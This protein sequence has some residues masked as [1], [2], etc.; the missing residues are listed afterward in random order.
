MRSIFK[1]FVVI[2]SLFLLSGCLDVEVDS[3]LDNGTDIILD[4]DDLNIQSNGMIYDESQDVYEVTQNLLLDEMYQTY[5]IIW[6][7]QNDTYLSDEGVVTRPTNGHDITVELIAHVLEQ[8]KTFTI[9]ILTIE[10]VKEPEIYQYYM[11]V[12]SDHNGFS[13]DTITR[14]Y[15]SYTLSISDL[16]VEGSYVLNDG[17]DQTV[18]VSF[19]LVE[20]EESHTYKHASKDVWYY[21]NDGYIEIY[22]INDDVYELV[23]LTTDSLQFVEENR[24]Y[25][26]DRSEIL[27]NDENYLSTYFDML[28]VSILYPIS[29]FSYSVDGIL[30]HGQFNTIQTEHFIILINNEYQLLFYK[31]EEKLELTMQ[32]LFD[33]Y[34]Q[35]YIDNYQSVI[36][37]ESQD[38]LD[39]IGETYDKDL[40]SDFKS[41]I[42]DFSHYS[43]Y[44]VDHTNGQVQ[45]IF[46]Q[47][48]GYVEYDGSGFKYYQTSDSHPYATHIGYQLNED[49]TKVEK[50]Y[51]HVSTYV[52]DLN[53]ILNDDDFSYV[54]VDNTYYLTISRSLFAQRYGIVNQYEGNNVYIKVDKNNDLLSFD[55]Y[56][57]DAWYLK[58]I[59]YHLS[60]SLR[61]DLDEVKTTVSSS[62]NDD[63]LP[64]KL[65]ETYTFNELNNSTRD[66]IFRINLD[67]GTYMIDASIGFLI[68]DKDGQIL[69]IEKHN[70]PVY[71]T[72]YVTL[73]EPLDAFLYANVDIHGDHYLSVEAIDEP[74]NEELVFTLDEDIE[75]D[76]MSDFDE[77]YIEHEV[78]IAKLYK[79]V[80][81]SDVGISMS[82]FDGLTTHQFWSTREVY[83][84]YVSLDA[85]ES[86]LF[87]AYDD[88]TIHI[89]EV[90]VEPITNEQKVLDE[91]QSM[92]FM[93]Q[94]T[95]DVPLFTFEVEDGMGYLQAYSAI[96]NWVGP[97]SEEHLKFSEQ[98]YRMHVYDSSGNAVDALNLSPGIYTVD[99]EMYGVFDIFYFDLK[100]VK[101]FE[102][103]ITMPYALDI[104][105]DQSHEITLSFDLE[106]KSFISFD[107]SHND[108]LTLYDDNGQPIYQITDH[109]VITLEVGSYQIKKKESYY[110]FVHLNIEI[111]NLGISTKEAFNAL[112]KSI[113][114]LDTSISFT[115]DHEIIRLSF[116]PV[117]FIYY[118][119]SNVKVYYLINELYTGNEIAPHVYNSYIISGVIQDTS[120]LLFYFDG[121]Y[122][123][124]IYVK[125]KTF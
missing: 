79:V 41:F 9:K 91:N 5:E 85:G 54:F 17:L 80:I 113:L 33:V 89:Y 75:I 53:A 119:A 90:E 22:T 30:Y 43:S 7:S 34:S 103:E 55:I 37:S 29:V 72:F 49:L 77:V 2:F 81:T 60:E 101:D 46:Y 100:I 124:D 107:T 68:V 51:D 65:D 64:I 57:D 35:L 52:P 104:Y 8:T 38:I 67:A 59:V 45:S 11:D 117:E 94:I 88:L 31:H 47:D 61:V 86:F 106:E 24:V 40:Q 25:Q 92:I 99:Y 36:L 26:K 63:L 66:Q 6:H 116:D 102:A 69:D 123:V 112:N 20:T 4:L 73:D 21:I 58:S 50:I 48:D 111:K 42:G 118:D 70:H 23:I 122:D 13:P 27:I 71:H 44:M 10:E 39:A 76:I 121:A 32:Q 97:F 3:D 1:A 16:S 83:V 12:S 14:S 28:Y 109:H 114:P 84:I 19:D 125:T 110:D 98:S 15:I 108:L 105:T 93:H 18:K 87:T 62:F 56:I 78:D 82:L 120:T 74:I 95:D 115:F 96:D